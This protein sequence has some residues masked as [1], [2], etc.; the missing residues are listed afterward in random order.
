MVFLASYLPL[1]AILL[2]QD[3]RF[4]LIG[5]PFCNP[6]S[7]GADCEFPFSNGAFSISIFLICL[8]CLGISLTTIHFVKAKRS[9]RIVSARHSPA[10][11]INYSIPYVVSFMSI[12]YDDTGKFIGLIIFLAWMF[13]LSHM[14][15]QIMLNP[16]LIAFGWRFYEITYRHNGSETPHSGF[17]LARDEIHVNEQWKHAQIRDILVLRKTNDARGNAST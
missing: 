17:A 4:E 6:F 7:S 9:I 2:A 16:V 15:G 5:K 1:S 14:S 11:L 8:T 13:W 3:F 10:E 12:G